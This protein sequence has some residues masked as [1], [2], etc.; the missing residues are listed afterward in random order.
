MHTLCS[1]A[2]WGQP[3]LTPHVQTSLEIGAYSVFRQLLV[4]GK[5]YSHIG[6]KS[7]AIIS[8]SS[9][10]T[11]KRASFSDDRPPLS[12]LIVN[13]LDKLELSGKINLNWGN[14]SI[15]LPIDKVCRH[16]LVIWEGPAYCGYCHQGFSFSLQI[17]ALR[18]CPNFFQWWAV[19]WKCN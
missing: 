1:S 19:M 18:S 9:L 11:V 15:R 8:A 3:F 14:A 12:W 6:L 7:V 17:P 5:I 16:L 4:A 10:Q 2:C 13:Q